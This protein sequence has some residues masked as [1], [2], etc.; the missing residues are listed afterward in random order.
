MGIFLSR[1]HLT[2]EG[3]TNRSPRNANT[4]R[5]IDHEIVPLKLIRQSQEALD[6][7]CAAT[8]GGIAILVDM[9]SGKIPWV[10]AINGCYLLQNARASSEDFK[11]IDP[12]HRKSTL[13]LRPYDG[14]E[15]FQS[16]YDWMSAD[17]VRGF[18]DTLRRFRSQSR[19]F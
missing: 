5:S 17:L 7:L 13:P 3:F 8:K 15:G 11:P 12:C 1:D 10:F 9:G 18:L 19:S 4:S 2:F 6:H 16:T 14:L